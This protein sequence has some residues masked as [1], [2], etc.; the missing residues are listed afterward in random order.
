M[1]ALPDLFSRLRQSGIAIRVNGEDL[2]YDAP[3]GALTPDLREE[4]RT[5]KLEIVRFLLQAN[6]SAASAVLPITAISCERD[7]PLSFA[8]QR[9]WFID[10][11]ESGS[12]LYNIPLA[13]RMTGPLEAGTLERC[14]SE[15]VRRHEVLR[16]TYQTVAGE[17]SQRVLPAT[18]LP[19]PLRDLSSLSEL[20]R[21]REV[22][23]LLAEEARRPFDLSADLMLR[24]GLLCLGEQEHIF[25]LV[26]H[27]IAVDGWSL[28]V[29][30]RELTAFYTAFLRGQPL[31]LPEL[32]IQYSDFAVWQQKRLQGNVLQEQLA[33]WKQCLDGAPSILELPTDHPRPATQ[34]YR[35]AQECV[36]FDE[37]L[38]R[39]LTRLGRQEGAT[40]FMVLLAAFKT[41]LYRYAGQEDIV[42]GTP[43]A[44]RNRLETEGLI[45]LFVN[46]LVLRTDLSG[47]P[48]FREL[49]TRVRVATL[50]AYAHQDLPFE[51][52]VDELNPERSLSRS[53]LFQVV[54][55][56]EN[57]THDTFRIPDVKVS[58]ETLEFGT[59][60]FDLTLSIN[61]D[62]DRLRGLLLYNTDLFERETIR[63][64]L[65]HFER[66]LVGIAADP[67]QRISQLPML[68][69][70]ER[71]QLLVDWN[72]TRSDYPDDR[73]VHELFEEQVER[74]PDAVA[75]E[76]K[77]QTLTYQQLNSRANRLAHH[78]QQIG[79]RPEVLVGLHFGRGL[80]MIVGLLGVWKA[81]GAYLPLDPTYPA[82]R[83]AFMIKDAGL[84]LILTKDDRVATLAGVT[85][86]IVCLDSQWEA[87]CAQE[88]NNLLCK[89]TPDNLAYVIYTS[90][91]TGRPK[92]VQ[93]VH[94]GLA[95]VADQCMRCLGLDRESRV[96]LFASFSFDAS[97]QDIVMTLCGGGTLCLAEKEELLPGPQ[98]LSLL[99][100]MEITHL[101][102]PPS[103]LAVLPYDDLPALRVLCVAGEPCA[104]ELVS[105]WS[106]GRRF[107]NI[108]GPTEGTICTTWHECGAETG[109]PP[110]GRPIGNVRVYVFDRHEQVTPVGVPG[111]LCLGG[112]GVARGYLNRSELTAEKFIVNPISG[113]PDVHLYRTGDLVRFQPDGNL[114]YLGR[115]DHQVKI[116]GFRIE[117]GEVESRLRSHPAIQDV[118]VVSREDSR[119][120]KRLV[121]YLVTGGDAPKAADLRSHLK[122]ELPEF[123]VPSAF[124]TLKALPLTPN[125]K[126]DRRA[127]PELEAGR[128]ELEQ[129]YAAPLTGIQ[130]VLAR[131]WAEMLE[132]DQVGIHDNFF[133]LGGHS[134][135]A[136]RVVS[137]VRSVL[138]AE[139]PVRSLFETPTIAGLAEQ[140]ERARGKADT[141][142]LVPLRP[143]ARDG[144]A[145]L[146][147]AQQ[148]LWFIDQ[149][150]PGGSVYNIPLAL[151]L[152][153]ALEVAALERSLG[154]I[155]RRHEALRTTI[156]NVSGEPARHLR[157]ATPLTLELTDLSGFAE[158]E[159]A[160]EVRRL[161]AAEAQRPFDLS[162][163]L[164]LRAGLLRLEE[165]E[166]VFFLTFH[167]MAADGWSMGVFFRELNLLYAAF[168]RGQTS[169]LTDLPIQYADFAAW[170][171]KWLQGD[172]LEKQLAYWKG[173][174][175]VPR[176]CWN[177]QRTIRGLPTRRIAARKS[178]CGSTRNCRRR[179]SS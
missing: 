109:P 149:L 96:L 137:Q 14:L 36:G 107:L 87:I 100:R 155:V 62:G 97:V 177:C 163:D 37:T 24:T 174:L 133:E 113:A 167:H 84:R 45:G 67:D 170:Q 141:A 121:A 103:S 48:T 164:M 2:Q 94:R 11:L 176:R 66:L 102:I 140:I 76:F 38:T 146:S 131:I 110:I 68:T 30:F 128:P 89:A 134:L 105:R 114:E 20:E 9:L 172:M 63:R 92:G 124:I 168:S 64:M 10:R 21:D 151:R 77:G 78:L 25:W 173:R 136:V 12:P 119:G 44:G 5:H 88:A 82:D 1:T 152:T 34:T 16:T 175:E 56:F 115:L 69:E 50:G 112:L 157:P 91:S 148:R 70:P 90:G 156:R 123:M 165:R 72:D 27:H 35:G 104:A 147:F 122:Q 55:S 43:I 171:R 129:G 95:N 99:R 28:G 116:R 80:E 86:K 46:T 132:L 4:L 154:E 178:A 161:L 143:V 153:G 166:H 144:D 118:V 120:E 57:D 49:L 31:P 26:F 127:L 83:L 18:V 159:R 60:N 29:F 73:C 160:G 81:G 139:I 108:Y 47:N 53:P 138:Q 162:S 145:P 71:H 125:G 111:E 59:S 117:L 17:P 135:A 93:L 13:L 42:V 41:L 65:G 3:P 98:L 179:C 33:Y 74:T 7:L 15:V 52:L 79:V 51:K 6:A 54:F 142:A 150:E 8:Q 85:S 61:C 169:P 106:R 130:T 23:Q 39:A 40:L 126:V 58:S 22:C 19:L 32:S 75:L 158:V 101:T